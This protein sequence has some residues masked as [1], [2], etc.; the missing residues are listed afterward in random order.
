MER[1]LKKVFSGSQISL[2]PLSINSS[3]VNSRRRLLA[4]IQIQSGSLSPE[5]A[6]QTSSFDNINLGGSNF[7]SLAMQRSKSKNSISVTK[8]SEKLAPIK[9]RERIMPVLPISGSRIYD[10]DQIPSVITSVSQK[11]MAGSTYNRLKKQNQD[12]L[13]AIQ[14]FNSNKSQ[15]LLG[16]MDG[17][18]VN[19]SQVSSYIKTSLPSLIEMRTYQD[20]NS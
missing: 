18:G 14:N 10:P 13:F 19:G 6:K 16:V 4:T 8:S 7:S 9:K 1:S 17:H 2:L 20:C 5:K 3:H 11:S 12:S 15:C